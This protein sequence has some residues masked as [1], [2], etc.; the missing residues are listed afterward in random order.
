MFPRD[1]VGPDQV[2]QRAAQ[3][4]L[5]GPLPAVGQGTVDH[6]RELA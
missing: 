4:L 6:D 3:P 1:A 2:R 5:S